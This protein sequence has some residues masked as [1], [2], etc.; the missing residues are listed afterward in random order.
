MSRKHGWFTLISDRSKSKGWRLDRNAARGTERPG[1]GWFVRAAVVLLA[2][3][4]AAE[5]F[6]QVGSFVAR[7]RPAAWRPS[8]TT[9]VL[10]VGDSHTYG[11]GLPED[12][13]YPAQLQSLLDVDAPGEFSVI[14]LGLPGMSTTQVRNRLPRFVTLYQPDIV[15][16][17]CGVNNAWNYSEVLGGGWKAQL[18][19]FA[20]HSRLYRFVTVLLHNR[21]LG[22][23]AEGTVG[24]GSHQPWERNVSIGE[25][26][27]FEIPAGDK[28]QT[29]TGQPR[30]ET[31][32]LRRGDKVE[33]IRHVHGPPREDDSVEARTHEDLREMMAWLERV[34]VPG[35]LIRYPQSVSAFGL[36][37]SA[38]LR[39]AAEAGVPVVDASISMSR[40][41]LEEREWLP[42][43][44]PNAALYH[45][46][47]K[48]VTP[49]VVAISKRDDD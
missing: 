39:V 29:Y 40:I 16:V 27:T 30:L 17:W 36:A 7:K 46:I 37:N 23:G 34:G 21:E 14:N 1:R 47:A 13:S 22:R 48:D 43:F 25:K 28:V 6:L 9:R 11:P 26:Q 15:I 38:I 41:P 8:A 35:V 45:E 32:E 18:A 42:G 2:V 33:T 4:L 24:E 31:Y 3:L 19:A 12:E 5:G 44:H 49:V 20:Y 10:A